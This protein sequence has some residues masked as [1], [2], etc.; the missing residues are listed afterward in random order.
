MVMSCWLTA[1]SRYLNQCW[2]I[3]SEVFRQS[4]QE[5]VTRNVFDI[6][7]G[8]GHE[9]FWYKITV[10]ANK[11]QMGSWLHLRIYTNL[12]FFCLIFTFSSYCALHRV[13]NSRLST[14]VIQS[15]LPISNKQFY[16]RSVIAEASCMDKYFHEDSFW[17]LS[18]LVQHL[19]DNVCSEISMPKQEI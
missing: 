1:L 15:I 5:N 3:I 11:C 9:H 10:V 6:H 19:Q 8:Y 14:L 18:S 17:E 13:I 16:S 2:L 7:P 12:I 4:P